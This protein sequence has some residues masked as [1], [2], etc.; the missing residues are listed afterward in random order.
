MIR[1]KAFLAGLAGFGCIVVFA[2]WFQCSPRSNSTGIDNT[3][4]TDTTSKILPL[5]VIAEQN[6]GT[7]GGTITVSDSSGS[8]NGIQISVPPAA[9]PTP[10]TYTVSAGTLSK[11]PFSNSTQLV[12]PVVRIANGGGYLDSALRIRIPIHISATQFAM[13]FL[14]L[15]SG[16]TLEA[17]PLIASDTNGVTVAL[18]HCGRNKSGLG[19]LQASSAATFVQIIIGSIDKS[20]LSAQGTIESGFEPGVDDWEFSNYGSYIAPGGHCSGQSLTAMW[21]YSE[22]RTSKA[23]ALFKRF[24]QIGL[25]AGDNN[26]GYRFASVIQE[27]QVFTGWVDGMNSQSILPSITWS[28]F[29]FAMLETH[30]PQ[31][32]LINN[33]AGK[34]GHAMIVY[35]IDPA[36]GILYIADPNYPANNTRTIEYKNGAFVPYSSALKVGDD[37]TDFDQIGFAAKTAYINWDAIGK[38]WSEFESKTIGTT[39]PESFPAYTIRHPGTPVQEIKDSL[40][41]DKDTFLLEVV[42]P[43]IALSIPATGLQFFDIYD[44]AGKL[45]YEAQ[46]TAV[47]GVPP[48]QIAVALNAGVNKL[49]LRITGLVKRKPTDTKAYAEYVDFKWIYITL[50]A[51]KILPADTTISADSSLK[52][53][54]SGAANRPAGS[55]IAWSFGDLSATQTIYTDSTVTHKFKQ[56]GACTVSVVLSDASNNV[57]SRGKTVITVSSGVPT[58]ATIGPD[59]LHSGDTI[60]ITGSGFGPKITPQSCVML[61]H[62]TL[63]NIL[64]W[65][66]KEIRLVLPDTASCGSIIIFIQNKYCSVNKQITPPWPAVTKLSSTVLHAFDTLTLTGKYLKRKDCSAQFERL[67]KFRI[68]GFE[69]NNPYNQLWYPD[70]VTWTDT[71]IRLVVPAASKTG[72]MF[73][74][75][76][77]TI[78]DSFPVEVPF[79]AN[80][81][82]AGVMTLSLDLQTTNKIS[83]ETYWSV[84]GRDPE[85]TIPGIDQSGSSLRFNSVPS[86]NIVRLDSIE[87]YKPLYSDS[88]TIENHLSLEVSVNSTTNMCTA[89]RV[90]MDYSRTSLTTAVKSQWSTVDISGMN[91]PLTGIALWSSTQHGKIMAY[92]FSVRGDTTLQHIG[93]FNYDTSNDSVVGKRA[94]PSSNIAVTIF[95]KIN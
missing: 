45:L 26:Y 67:I 75:L 30:E 43:D 85:I 38:R 62:D 65:S 57:L 40:T 15:D 58:I 92:T 34:G 87:K 31:S 70:F 32:V 88:A 51:L 80:N 24:G 49:G 8:V 78:I 41:T 91:L 95:R 46:G 72:T 66:E 86:N 83:N 73:M 17:L 50:S 12:S 81:L 53:T 48:G 60:T 7:S 6:I 56:S 5:R 74:L 59:T 19:K 29:V 25:G 79:D 23:N 54:V 94:T 44:P 68:P 9:S 47:D 69:S 22:K 27:D 35:K 33:S 36:A 77:D 82:V 4:P 84:N 93:T 63:K 11:T 89:F 16:K 64:S 14:Y 1:T 42:C 39:G 21:Y 10:R 13:G 90:K 61:E 52:L 55:K 20:K 18:R 28:A 76:N 37:G 3:D 2:L 71:T